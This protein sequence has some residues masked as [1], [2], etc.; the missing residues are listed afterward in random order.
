MA[1]Y[2]P[3]VAVFFQ[4]AGG[5]VERVKVTRINNFSHHDFQSK[6]MVYTSQP[7]VSDVSEFND[8]GVQVKKSGILTV[9]RGVPDGDRTLAAELQQAQGK[10]ASTFNVALYLGK[11]GE[12]WQESIDR[13]GSH[14]LSD[15]NVTYAKLAVNRSTGRLF[16]TVTFKQKS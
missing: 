12:T 11:W 9:S 7:V 3:H 6:S 1:D 16:Q 14:E 15:V 5:K 8:D 13:R 10:S 4:D 2:Y